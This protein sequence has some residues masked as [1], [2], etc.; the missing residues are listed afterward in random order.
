MAGTLPNL[1]VLPP[2]APE[3][4]IRDLNTSDGAI[5]LVT[6]MFQPPTPPEDYTG[7]MPRSISAMDDDELGDLLVKAG[8]WTG[9]VDFELA[10][11]EAQRE[12]AKA[13]Y[14]FIRA[15][16]RLSLRNDN[17]GKKLT[18]SDKDDLVDTDPR[19]VEAYSRWLTTKA[20][21][22]L[23]RVIRDKSQRNWDTI[24]RRITQ[25]GQGVERSKREHSVNAVP[26]MAARTFRRP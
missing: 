26:A 24:S 7:W 8:E 18:V 2:S 9:H 15:R 22:E 16:I 13:Q 20:V 17:E 12:S 1:A 10:K 5:S 14:D 3:E 6:R 19:V 4:G 21:Y 11:A 25:R 23:T